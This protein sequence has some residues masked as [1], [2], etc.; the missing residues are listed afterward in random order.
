[1]EN[2]IILLTACVNPQGMTYTA[3]QDKDERLRQ[4]QHA[5]QWYLDNT[6]SPILF[7]ENTGYDITPMYA[8]AIASGRLEVLTFQGNDFDK[9]KGKGYGEALIIEY[10]LTH[11]EF[12]KGDVNVL[13]ITGRLICENVGKMA[14]RYTDTDTVYGQKLQ[15]PD[16]NMEMSSQVIVAPTTFWKDY[17]ISQ[18]EGIDDGAHYWFEHLLLDAAMQWRKDGHNYK[19][20]WIPTALTGISGSSGDMISSNTLKARISFYLHYVLGKFG[21]Y[22]AIRP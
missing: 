1:M 11:S 9:S 19:D 13:K 16:G 8:D 17:F 21:Y 18:K 10:A 3:L 14:R 4:Y 6:K 15:D 2:T 12:L 5:L 7:V 22:G 20:M